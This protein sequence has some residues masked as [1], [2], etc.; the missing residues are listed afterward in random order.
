MSTAI[1]QTWPRQTL[2]PPLTGTL[3]Y[4]RWYLKGDSGPWCYHVGLR[5][6]NPVSATEWKPFALL[7][8]LADWVWRL[9]NDSTRRDSDYL[10]YA[11][12]YQVSLAFN[13][14]MFIFT[15]FSSLFIPR[16][17]KLYRHSLEG[18]RWEERAPER[19]RTLWAQR[20]RIPQL[21]ATTWRARR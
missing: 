19:Y 11:N 14:H 15:L 5:N 12:G 18:A 7:Y 9:F 6:T 2:E 8:W 21:E 20:V 4:P 16:S 1:S 3:L 10:W 13:L 17:F